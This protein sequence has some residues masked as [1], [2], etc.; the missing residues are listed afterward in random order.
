MSHLNYFYYLKVEDFMYSR[1]ITD[2]IKEAVKI[3]ERLGDIDC[4]AIS[5]KEV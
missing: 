1:R 3:L 2:K 5:S 4:K